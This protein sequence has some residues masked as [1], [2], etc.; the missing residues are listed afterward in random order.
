MKKIG[1]K[2]EEH[3]E[4]GAELKLIRDEL[5]HLSVTIA[6]RYPKDIADNLVEAVENIDRVRS[7]LDDCVCEENPELE[8]NILF[9]CYYGDITNR[10]GILRVNKPS[11]AR[12]S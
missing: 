5:V 6:N 12:P 8:D 4:V 1:F 10:I 11:S 9:S 7:D 3:A 2:F